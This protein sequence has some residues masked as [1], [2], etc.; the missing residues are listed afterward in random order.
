MQTKAKSYS[1]FFGVGGG[2]FELHNWL[3]FEVLTTSNYYTLERLLLLRG[4]A[5]KKKTYRPNSIFQLWFPQF[6]IINFDQKRLE[7]ATQQR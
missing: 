4:K 2:K 6:S 7:N 3:Q 5:E 1:L